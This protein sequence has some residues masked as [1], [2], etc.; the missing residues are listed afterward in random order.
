MGTEFKDEI[1]GLIDKRSQAYTDI[2]DAI[3]GFAEPQ[4]PG[5]GVLQDPA[6]VFKLQ[7]LFRPGRSGWRGNCVHSRIRQREAGDRIFRRI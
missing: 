3:W 6:G 2:S 4:I 7:R 1:E 5:A